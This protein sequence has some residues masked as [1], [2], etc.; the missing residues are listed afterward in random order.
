M[1]INVEKIKEYTTCR[2]LVK[3]F[4]LVQQTES[5]N[6][7]AAKILADSLSGKGLIVFAETQTAGKGR[8]GDPWIDL[9]SESLLLSMIPDIQYCP[10]SEQ[11]GL[12][13]IASSVA[14]AE[15]I[16]NLLPG[17][18]SIKW[19]NDILVQSLKLCGILVENIKIRNSQRPIIGIG[20]N[21]HQEPRFFNEK[22][23]NGATSLDIQ[24]NSYNDRNALAAAIIE[25]HE[26]Y[27][28]LASHGKINEVI[29]A[30]QSY[31]F[32]AG[33]RLTIRSN[34]KLYTGTCIS[35]E[36]LKG[37]T[38]VTDSGREIFFN[39]ATATIVS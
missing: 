38:I 24:T 7:L 19:P 25:S 15:V 22:N 28:H 37:I 21:C 13:V 10:E 32:Q 8:K 30:W 17:E 5:T 4:I 29:T 16:A 39:S 3:D 35:L 26:K 27:L 14:M 12:T 33:S 9:R 1:A 23:L 36:P 11:A 31:N 2:W 6:K 20:L 18:V 34:N